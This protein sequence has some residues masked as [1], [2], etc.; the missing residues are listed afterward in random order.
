MSHPFKK[1]TCCFAQNAFTRFVEAH[2][3]AVW[4][5]AR[6]LFCMCLVSHAQHHQ[7]DHILIQR[8]VWPIYFASTTLAPHRKK[9]VQKIKLDKLGKYNNQLSHFSN[10]RMVE[11]QNSSLPQFLPPTL[12]K[13]KISSQDFEQH[14]T[15]IPPNVTELSISKYSNFDSIF[16]NLPESI[17]SVKCNEINIANTSHLTNLTALTFSRTTNSKRSYLPTSIKKLSI[18]CCDLPLFDEEMILPPTLI[19]LYLYRVV[20]TNIIFPTTLTKLCFGTDAPLQPNVFPISLTWLELS[21]FNQDLKE[22]MIPPNLN[23]LIMPKFNKQLSI[24]I[25]PMSLAHLKIGDGFCNPIAVLYT[26]LTSLMFYSRKTFDT[27]DLPPNLIKFKCCWYSNIKHHTLSLFSSSLKILKMSQNMQ[28][29]ILPCNLT[30]LRMGLTRPCTTTFP[31]SLVELDICCEPELL[32]LNL[33]ISL[34]NLVFRFKATTTGLNHL[35]LPLHLTTLYLFAPFSYKNN[36]L[37]LKSE[38]FN[39][40]TSLTSLK[41]GYSLSFENVQFPKSLLF[42]D[43]SECLYGEI[44]SSVIPPNLRTLTM[45]R[46]NCGY[47]HLN[48]Q[49]RSRVK[50]SV[51][52]TLH[53]LH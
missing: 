9:H 25:L 16:I 43:I 19:E 14:P 2:A 12:K 39:N 1:K 7:F 10:C 26:N 41:L 13:L 36:T 20:D 42:L 32:P 27:H 53:F 34:T 49:L 52:R 24:G 50:H 28:V 51:S 44:N 17:V 47:K 23:T 21:M 45:S 22:N 18:N 6:D 30:S 15:N 37:I 46:S 4:L 33:P 48:F 38:H 5:D 8:L 31:N 11:V 29:D 40:M 35:C 3:L